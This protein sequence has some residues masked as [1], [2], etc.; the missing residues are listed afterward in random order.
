MI[1]VAATVVSVILACNYNGV[2]VTVDWC[3]IMLALGDEIL[4]CIY[5]LVCWFGDIY[6]CIMYDR[7]C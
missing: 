7:N 6:S 4:A 2:T 1:V 3:L 5:L